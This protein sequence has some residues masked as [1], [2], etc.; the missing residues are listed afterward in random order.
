MTGDALGLPNVGVA[1][2]I[3][4]YT[5]CAEDMLDSNGITIQIGWWEASLMFGQHGWGGSLGMG[6]QSSELIPGARLP[7]GATVNLDQGD[8]VGLPQHFGLT[9]KAWSSKW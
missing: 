6:L 5:G 8:I 1:G 4:F 2:Q 3:G 7:F 9:P